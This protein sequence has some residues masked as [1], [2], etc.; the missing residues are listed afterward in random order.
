MFLGQGHTAVPGYTRVHET[1]PSSPPFGV[2]YL[3]EPSVDMFAARLGQRGVRRRALPSRSRSRPRLV[4]GGLQTRKHR[5]SFAGYPFPPCLAERGDWRRISMDPGLK[6]RPDFL[7][8]AH[9]F[10][11]LYS[12][13]LTHAMICQNSGFPVRGQVC[14]VLRSNFRRASYRVLCVSRGVRSKFFFLPGVRGFL[15]GTFTLSQGNF[16]VALWT[17]HRAS[18][19]FSLPRLLASN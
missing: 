2:Y 14:G 10:F 6:D 19:E 16:L 11:C 8:P 18:Y 4:C 17:V 13:L 9:V 1:Y 3:R 7:L 12:Y 5:I 15:W